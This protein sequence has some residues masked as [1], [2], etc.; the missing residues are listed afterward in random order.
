M[1]FAHLDAATIEEVRKAAVAIGIATDDGYRD[2][3]AQVNRAF[4]GVVAGASPLAKLNNLLT[5]MNETRVLTSGEVPLEVWLKTVII[6]SGGGPEELVFRTALERMSI[7]GAAPVQAGAAAPAATDAEDVPRTDGELEIAIGEDDT[8]LV[9]FLHDGARAAGSVAKLLVHRHF[10]G[11]PAFVAGN[12]PEL[13]KGTGWV[14]APGLLI[15]NHHVVNA[16]LPQ[17]P[18]ASATD[19]ALQG[20]AVQVFFDYYDAPEPSPIHSVRCEASDP[21]LDF[22]LL[23]IPDQRAPLRLRANPI[24]RPKDRQ[25][26]E[27]VN[28]LQHPDGA[29]MRLGFRNNFVVTGTADRLSYLTDTAGGSSGSPICDDAWFVAALHRG[30]QTIDGAPL[31]VWGVPI[32]QENY[33][34]PIDKVVAFLAAQHPALHAE[35]VAGQQAIGG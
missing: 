4:V 9:Q 24:T 5:K 7:D 26:R 31:M 30:F 12:A 29:P 35:I 21:T 16:R 8:L 2:S 3:T 17:E 22:A 6:L 23:R 27:R 25:L 14:L 13:G 34:T 1:T 11:Q 28:V 20:A 19:F 10:D 18:A 33:G 15:T 32:R